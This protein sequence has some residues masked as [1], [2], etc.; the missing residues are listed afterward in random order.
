MPETRMK[1]GVTKRI[2][3]TIEALEKGELKNALFLTDRNEMQ[4]EHAWVEDAARKV[5][6]D[7]DNAKK[8]MLEAKDKLKA[9]LTYPLGDTSLEGVEQML[10]DTTPRSELPKQEKTDEELYEEC[11]ECHIATAVA[12]ATEICE[13]HPQ[14]VCSLITERLDRE[15]TPPEEWIRAL[16]EAANQAQ[17]EAKAEFAIILGDLSDYLKR[18]NSPFLKALTT[19]E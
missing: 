19:P 2:E 10:K 17:G 6:T 16:K 8:Y 11:E 5:L 15:D 1:G 13:K 3:D 9:T 4:R 18:K 12:A 14:T 7:R